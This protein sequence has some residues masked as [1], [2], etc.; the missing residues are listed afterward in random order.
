MS[1]TKRWTNWLACHALFKKLILKS[2]IIIQFPKSSY[3]T[4]AAVTYHT[5]AGKCPGFWIQFSSNS[6]THE[7]PA[8]FVLLIPASSTTWLFTLMLHIWLISPVILQITAS[9]QPGP[10]GSV[11]SPVSILENVTVT[12]GV[13]RQCFSS[14]KLQPG[15]WVLNFL[16]RHFPL[17]V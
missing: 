8:H 3:S 10:Q 16:L 9:C 5:L 4:L 13:A 2:G 7:A 14:E 6:A 17:N 12:A 1:T 11:L 15:F